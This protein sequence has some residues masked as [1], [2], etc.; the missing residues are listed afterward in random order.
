MRNPWGAYPG[1]T[2]V[3]IEN[4][5]RAGENATLLRVAYNFPRR[6]SLSL[7]GLWVHGSTPDV[8]NNTHKANTTS[9]CNGTR[10]GDLQKTA[11]ARALRARLAGGPSDQHENELRLLVYY[12]L[13]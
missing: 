12:Q 3:Q 2:A 7:Y 4:F 11:T 13:R 1:Y 8:P 10:R 6:T 5:Y 9:M